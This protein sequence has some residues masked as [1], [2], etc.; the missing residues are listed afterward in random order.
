[1]PPVLMEKLYA[2]ELP[3][4][5]A[6]SMIIDGRYLPPPEDKDGKFWVRTS[7]LIQASPNDL[8]ARWRNVESA[9]RDWPSSC[10]RESSLT[11]E[12]TYLLVGDGCG[13]NKPCFHLVCRH[14]AQEVN[15][16]SL[17]RG[18]IFVVFAWFNKRGHPVVDGRH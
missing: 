17:C 15:G 13:I 1:M 3:V 18:K 2:E 5:G 4:V 12:E 7:A 6:A 9:L 16:R 8:Y 14:D 11:I 10:S